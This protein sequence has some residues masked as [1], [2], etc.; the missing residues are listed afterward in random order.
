[1]VN[2]NDPAQLIIASTQPFPENEAA[3]WWVTFDA[4][5]LF[6]KELRDCN[7]AL[8]NAANGFR[9]QFARKRVAGAGN[10]KELEKTRRNSG[11]GANGY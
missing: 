1:M 6:D 11:L 10:V 3:A 4:I 5:A 8:G 9:P 7:E 2:P